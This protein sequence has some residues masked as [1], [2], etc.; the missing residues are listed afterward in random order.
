MSLPKGP[1]C[2]ATRLVFVLVKCPSGNRH[3]SETQKTL[4]GM[5]HPLS[6]DDATAADLLA[7][8]FAALPA[9]LRQRHKD[10]SSRD[11]LS[12]A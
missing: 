6:F 9:N 10:T 7:L 11:K 12:V 5:M 2:I 3:H 8:P 1:C 4:K